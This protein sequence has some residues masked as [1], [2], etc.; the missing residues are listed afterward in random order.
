MFMRPTV[1]NSK[2]EERVKTVPKM[3]P[4][5]VVSKYISPVFQVIF[6]IGLQLVGNEKKYSRQNASRLTYQVK[7]LFHEVSGEFS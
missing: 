4:Q 2:M 1:T 3:P 7:L 5:A 6:S